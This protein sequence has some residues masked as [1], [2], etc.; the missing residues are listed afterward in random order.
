MGLRARVSGI[1]KAELTYSHTCL[2]CI[3]TAT[4]LCVAFV[5]HIESQAD[6]WLWTCPKTC[7]AAEKAFLSS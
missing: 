6:C 2:T 5:L 7:R 1:D 3:T 4:L